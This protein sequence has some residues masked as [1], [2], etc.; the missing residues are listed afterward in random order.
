M[1][2]HIKVINSNTVLF[3]GVTTKQDCFTLQGDVGTALRH[4]P[5]L[6]KEKVHEYFSGCD[7]HINWETSCVESDDLDEEAL[8][9]SIQDN[10][11]NRKL[12][13]YVEE[14]SKNDHILLINWRLF[15]DQL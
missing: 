3:C 5:F 4:L 9:V 14:Q 13:C 2:G 12:L 7:T 6:I 10:N 11:G 15:T 1:T 8:Y